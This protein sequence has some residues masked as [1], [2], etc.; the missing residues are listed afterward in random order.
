MILLTSLTSPMDFG[1][2]YAETDMAQFPVEPWNTYSNLLFLFLVASFAYRTKLD[3]KRFPFIVFALP[4]LLLGFVGGTMYHA[5]RS[6]SLW[7]ILDFVPIGILTI[8]AGVYFWRRLLRSWWYALF[9][10]V[11]IAFSIRYCG[12]LL[13]LERHAQISLGYASLAFGILLPAVLYCRTRTWFGW[14]YLCGA[15]VSFLVAV[16]FRRYDLFLSAV[17]LPMG[18]HFLWHIGGAVST[19]CLMQYLYLDMKKEP[20]L[21]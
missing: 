4:I 15:T 12:V 19:G 7:L 6:H 20:E 9:V 5:T 11:V 3:W 18:T 1:P 2:L 21:I 16:T 10:T 13:G 17:W 14:Q 8:S